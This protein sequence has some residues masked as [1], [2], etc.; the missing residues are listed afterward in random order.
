VFHEEIKYGGS[1]RKKV[2]LNPREE[3]QQKIEAADLRGLLLKTGELHGH[4]CPFVA[5]GVK[6]SVIALKR[7]ETFTEGIDE[8]MA[9]IVEVNNCFVDGVQ[10][11]TGCTLGNNAL[12]YKDFGK[13]AVT[14]V[15]NRWFRKR[16]GQAKDLEREPGR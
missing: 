4:F 6:A 16:F 5:L 8:E 13:N 15:V 3:I 12:I 11:V 10:M 14:L 9:A 1:R 7:L 2:S